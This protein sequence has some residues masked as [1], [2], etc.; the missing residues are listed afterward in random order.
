MS[1]SVRRPLRWSIIQLT[2]CSTADALSALS[3]S[4]PVVGFL[5]V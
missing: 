3:P 2:R 5:R 4:D 1:V